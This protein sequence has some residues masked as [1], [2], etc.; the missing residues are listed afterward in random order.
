M[1]L[2]INGTNNTIFTTDTTLTMKTGTSVTAQT[3]DTAG[4][5]FS[6]N[7][8]QAMQHINNGQG[9]LSYWTYS[10]QSSPDG[11]RGSA[12]NQ[13][14]GRFTAPVTGLYQFATHGIPVGNT[15]DSRMAY[16]VN[17]S[18][19]SRTICATQ[20]GS[21]GGLTGHPVSLYLTAGDYVNYAMYSGVGSHTGTWSGFSGCLIS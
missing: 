10:T 17:D 14:N 11:V 19:V 4:R 7:R 20:N 15:G 3:F 2:S 16:Y 1:P 8:V 21:H 12:L 18:I 5:S 9:T 13:G 6:A